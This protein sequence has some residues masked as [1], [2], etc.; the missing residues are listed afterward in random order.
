[1]VMRAVGISVWEGSLR[2]EENKF[3]KYRKMDKSSM[4]IQVLLKF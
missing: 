3:I 2:A 1:M 4:K